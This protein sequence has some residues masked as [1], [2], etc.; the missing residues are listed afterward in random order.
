MNKD[1][2]Y[3]YIEA[4]AHDTSGWTLI[5][6]TEEDVHERMNKLMLKI[7]AEAYDE[8]YKAGANQKDNKPCVCGFWKDK[9]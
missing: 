6:G 8:G 5:S 9:K 3:K 2:F 7:R 1:D 4:D